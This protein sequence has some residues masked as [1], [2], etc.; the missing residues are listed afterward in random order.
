LKTKKQQAPAGRA[1]A[2]QKGQIK[3]KYY[4]IETTKNGVLYKRYKCIEGWT[5]EKH[6]NLCWKF[7]KQGA[8]QIADRLN[9]ELNEYWQN[10][11]HYNIIEAE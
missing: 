5:T 7:S 9:N 1:K 11:I 3:M 4:V 10:K 6:K 2:P 8:R